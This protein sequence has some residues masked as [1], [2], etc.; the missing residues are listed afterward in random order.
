MPTTQSSRRS[1]CS[2]NEAFPKPNAGEIG[3]MDRSSITDGAAFTRRGE[4]W[5]EVTRLT[6]A[7]FRIR[8]GGPFHGA[9]LATLSNAL[10]A[11]HISIDHV[12]ARL[13]GDETWIAEFHLLVSGGSPD[14]LTLDY[15]ALA[16]G[17]STAP[18]GAFTL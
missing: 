13:I 17:A 9:W 18:V 11:R 2:H 7:A 6:G 12:H 14:L 10:A 16:A 15:I 4:A 8:L 3:R 5:S 1:P